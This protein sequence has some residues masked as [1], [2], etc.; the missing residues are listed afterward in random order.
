VERVN[1]KVSMRAMFYYIKTHLE[2]AYYMQSSRVAGFLS[3]M[4]TPNGKRYF[5]TLKERLDQF[6]ALEYDHEPEK[7]REVE[8]IKPK[9]VTNGRDDY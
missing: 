9:N 3:D 5:D 7:P 4:V 2:S 1:L 8:V 6:Q